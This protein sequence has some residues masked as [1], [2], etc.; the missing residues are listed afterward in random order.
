V[1]TQ[2]EQVTKKPYLFKKQKHFALRIISLNTALVGIGYG[3]FETQRYSRA[4]KE[5]D[6]LS[7][8][9]QEN[10]IQHTAPEWDKARKNTTTHG[11][12]MVMG[13]GIGLLGAVVCIFTF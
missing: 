12:S 5:L 9:T 8:V 2:T 3:I 6:R 4:K 10:M 11:V 1:L 7:L 13:Y